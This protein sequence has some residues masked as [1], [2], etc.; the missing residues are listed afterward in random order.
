MT[1]YDLSVDFAGLRLKN[2]L[3]AD[4]AGYAVSPAG[5]RRLLK[6]G[7]GAVITKSSTGEALPAWPRRWEWSPRPRVYWDDVTLPYPHSK[8]MDGTEALI[9]PGYKRMAS[10]IKEVKP[11]ADELDAYIIGSFSPRSEQEAAEIAREYEKAGASAIHMDLVCSTAASF[12][13]RQHPSKGWEKLGNWWSETPERAAGVMKA[14]KDAVDIPVV[15]KSFFLTWAKERPEA[16]KMIE[17]TS[18]IDGLA[19]HTY[20]IPG[21]VWIDI[22]RGKPYAYPKYPSMDAIVALTVGNTMNLAKVTKKPIL[23]AGAISTVSD[24]IQL[25]MVGGTA[26]GLCRALY[27]DIHVV[28]QICDDLESYMASQTLESLDEIRGIA[29]KYPLKGPSGLAPEYE[30]QAVPLDQVKETR[31][32]K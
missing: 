20:S 16:I 23:T 31:T 29:L 24:V 10:Y 5:L 19:V 3:L 28:K 25:I 8:T 9:N 22:F 4:A 32:R 7:L 30:D 14:A 2:P 17:E 12:R 15:P 11:L 26:I 21:C 6:S 18:R 1:D 13:G 27:K